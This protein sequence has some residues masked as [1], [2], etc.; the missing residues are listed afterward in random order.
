MITF[1]FDGIDFVSTKKCESII[2]VG[3]QKTLFDY[4]LYVVSSGC[5]LFNRSGSV[6]RLSMTMSAQLYMFV[7]LC[8]INN[9]L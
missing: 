1:Y 9:I 3:V 4:Y 5:F 6:H 7:L 8:F 2:E